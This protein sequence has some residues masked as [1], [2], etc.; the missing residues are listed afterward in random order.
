MKRILIT[1]ILSIIVFVV[2]L[3]ATDMYVSK[4]SLET[5]DYL[6]DIELDNFRSELDGDILLT[7]QSVKCFLSGNTSVSVDKDGLVVLDQR[8]LKQ[9]MDGI[10]DNLHQFMKVNPFYEASMFIID[11]DAARSSLGMKGYYVPLVRQ[12]DTALVDLAHKYDF[13]HSVHYQQLKREKKIMW[14]VPSSQSPVA[15]KFMTLYMPLLLSDGSFFGAFAVSLDIKMINNKLKKY[16][17]YGEEYS[18]MFLMDADDNIFSAWPPSFITH[19]DKLKSILREFE[20]SDSVSRSIRLQYEGEDYYAYCRQTAHAPWTIY[21]VCLED[22]IYESA[23]Q[24]KH[25]VYI[26]SIV[27]MLLML[28]CCVVISRQISTNM[29]RKAA[30]EDE[31][32]MASRVQMSL[33][34]PASFGNRLSAYIKP[35]R[36]A[37]GDL[38][39]Y[40]EKDGKLIFCI[41]DVSGKGMPAALFM[42]QVVS[43]FR[44]AVSRTADPA[45]ITTQINDVLAQNNPDMT[46]CT[47][48]VGVLDNGTLTFCNAGHNPPVIIPENRTNEES[49]FVAVKPNVALGLMEGYP[50]RNEALAMNQ[51]DSLLLYTDGV[52]EAKN[53]ERREFGESRLMGSLSHKATGEHSESDDEVILSVLG[54]LHPFVGDYE[55]SDDITMVHVTV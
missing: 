11:D 35:S 30:V 10:D 19:Q 27:G 34:K 51:G 43:L 15:G 4:K 40:I 29:R 32:R 6:N 22:R 21:T 55:Q 33:L 53:R 54:D 49:H 36:E 18:S 12:G 1:L 17:P 23:N 14:T 26:S 44:N 48:F 8:H 28:L 45:E 50:Y 24:F 3:V 13:S 5:A 2:T 39:D 20:P 41:G 47:F 25:V 37:G 38:Y 31:L 9:F 52:T 16:L 46:F 42:T 7:E